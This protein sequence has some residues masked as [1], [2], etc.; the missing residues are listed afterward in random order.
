MRETVLANAFKLHRFMLLFQ[1]HII[2]KKVSI[3]FLKRHGVEPC[4][5]INDE[6]IIFKP[7]T[8]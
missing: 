7:K 3:Y 2:C 4:S 8:N 5:K 1:P 6:R